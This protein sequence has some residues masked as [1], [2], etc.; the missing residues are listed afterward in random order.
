MIDVKD[1]H[2][3]DAL[4][5]DLRK[6]IDALCIEPKHVRDLWERSHTARTFSSGGEILFCTGLI[7]VD[8]CD[9]IWMLVDS[10]IQTHKEILSLLKAIRGELDK[11]QTRP[12]VALV[13][14]SFSVGKKFARFFG[15]KDS[16]HS[17]MIHGKL[18]QIYIKAL[19]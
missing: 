5:V 17:E 18:R 4:Y 7:K 11:A 9:F 2:P 14:E 6:E 12:I 8:E 1:F 19:T 13:D 3:W 10:S 15:F 16:E